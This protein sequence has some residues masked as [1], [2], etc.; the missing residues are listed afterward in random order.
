MPDL[1]ILV[2]GD[3][4]RDEFRDAVRCLEKHGPI[5]VCSIPAGS[6]PPVDDEAPPDLMVLL[7]SRPGEFSAAAVDR[8]MQN[9]PLA[10]V[11][12][13]L[14]SWCEGEMRSGQPWPGVARVYW[15]QAAAR[16]ERELAAIHQGRAS[17]W[18]LPITATEEERLLAAADGTTKSAA[19]LVVIHAAAIETAEWLCAA[20]RSHGFEAVSIRSGIVPST[21]Q[22]VAAIYDGCLADER[23]LCVVRN[24]AVA[25]E[26]APLLVLL[27]F[28]RVEDH[29]RMQAAGAAMV[30]GKPVLID[31]LIS[32]LAQA[33]ACREAVPEQRG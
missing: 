28:P 8:L 1:S 3:T 19:G 33:T 4:Q 20:C 15:H 18:G 7:S 9:A 12:A 16:L 30:L 29:R 13:V 11:I 2:I 5:N 31:D 14:G 26:G 27:N 10:R 6:G 21:L 23:E 32:A 25:L 22:P 24:L 17:G